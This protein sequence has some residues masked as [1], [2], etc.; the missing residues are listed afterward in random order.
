[1]RI[2]KLLLGMALA[3]LAM[4]AAAAANRTEKSATDAKETKYC[5]QYEKSTGSRIRGSECL[6]KS[7]WAKRGVDV[8]NLARK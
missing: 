3:G 2:N 4:P 5:I 8:D 1:M 7:E 6:T